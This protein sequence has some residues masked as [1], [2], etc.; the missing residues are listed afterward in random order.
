MKNRNILLMLIIVLIIII[1]IIMCILLLNR[2]EKE[3]FNENNTIIENTSKP[4]IKSVDDNSKFFTVANCVSQYLS[5]INK[6]NDKYYA[7]DDDGSYKKI[8][9]ENYIKQNIYGLLSQEYIEKNNIT[10]NNLYDYI[11]D[12]NE[13]V[14]F[15]PINMNVLSGTDVE[16][17]IAYGFILNGSNE[18]MKE[19]YIILNLD[20]NNKTFSVEQ[21]N[22]QYS[23]IDEIQIDNKEIAIEKRDN[24][25]FNYVNATHEYIIKQ[26]LNVYKRLALS[27]PEVAYNY[28]DEE[29]RIARFGNL[30]GY[31]AYVEK[32]RNSIFAKTVTKYKVSQEDEYK[33]YVCITQDDDYYIF[34]EKSVMDYSVILDTYTIDLPEYIEK[35]NSSS[36]NQKVALCIDKFIK[37]INDEN[38]TL[39]YNMLAESFKNNY[40]KTQ[41]SFEEYAKQNLLGKNNVTFGSFG[42]EADAYYTYTV[43]LNNENNTNSA[44]KTFI[45]RLKTGTNF[46]LSFNV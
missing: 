5:E 13:Q 33:Q 27:K 6:N 19:I 42:N 9:E 34:R 44:Q 23:S 17:Y 35:Y 46:E 45:I 10:I 4:E 14:M 39:A 29:Y 3:L 2:N 25:T 37:V 40:F 22:N 18:L 8:V 11:Y 7:M 15:V 32:N 1:L 21:I 30:E 12:F 16:K 24:N 43:T 26:Y 28:L 20:I 41:A 38:Y 31:K 36:E